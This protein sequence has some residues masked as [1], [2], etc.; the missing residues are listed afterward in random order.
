MTRSRL[1]FLSTDHDRH[2]N[3]RCY[4][5]QPGK[6]KVRI[7]EQ[8]EDENGCITE[9]FMAAYRLAVSGK[10]PDTPKPRK[11]IE[12]SFNWLV[13]RYYKSSDWSSF[14]PETQKLKKGI[15]DKFL[16][17]A[18]E[19]PFE[20]YRQE[21]LIRSRDKRK[22]TPAAADNFVKVIRRLF[23]WAIEQKITTVAN[24]A[25]KV[26][27]IHKSE[28]HHTWTPSEA[29]KYRRRHPIRTKARLAF[30]MLH[31]LGVRRSD[32][33]RLGA[34]HEDRGL[35][36]FTAW[37]NRNRFPVEVI[38][39]IPNEMREAMNATILGET[40]YLV[41]D[42]G[43]P[44]TVAGFGNQFKKWCIEAGLPHCSSHGV[45]KAAAVDLAEKGGSSEELKATF[46]WSKSETAEEYT[47]KA[48]KRILAKNAARRRGSPGD[49]V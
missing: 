1:K 25:Y 38:V 15:L 35:L 9:S 2:G 5:R 22:E 11:K 40:T 13:D 37:K 7:K 33:V 29:E 48:Q 16:K 12:R 41:N 21:D 26:S 28:G 36:I 4:V 39:T 42:E 18:G 43:K 3:V 23:N 20:S 17:T 44:Y 45:R 10:A 8:F 24:P 47:R 31:G 19:L 49:A 32:V 30:E 34:Q 46:G 14:A 27:K 6:L